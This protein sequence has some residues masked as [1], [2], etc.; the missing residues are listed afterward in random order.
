MMVLQSDDRRDRENEVVRRH[1][2]NLHGG[3]VD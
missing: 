1:R 3:K 2:Q